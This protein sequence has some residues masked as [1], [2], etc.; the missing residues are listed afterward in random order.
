MRKTNEAF[1]KLGKE[2]NLKLHLRLYALFELIKYTCK[3]AATFPPTFPSLFHCC[4]KT[5]SRTAK[6]CAM[7]I[8]VLWGLLWGRR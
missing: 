6:Y 8:M 4:L 7:Y 5:F 2:S 3:A 1:P